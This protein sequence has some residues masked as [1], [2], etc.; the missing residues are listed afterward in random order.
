MPRSGRADAPDCAAEGRGVSSSMWLA[1]GHVHPWEARTKT[2]SS[3]TSY[4]HTVS[5][6]D[7][8]W[9]TSAHKGDGAAVRLLH[10]ARAHSR[11]RRTASRPSPTRRIIRWNERRY[12]YSAC[13]R[14]V[15]YIT[16]ILL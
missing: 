9:L 2:H 10:S 8:R 6:R 16:L 7:L 12:Q 5:G 4:E 11:R 1:C 3:A 13:V 14:L 15:L